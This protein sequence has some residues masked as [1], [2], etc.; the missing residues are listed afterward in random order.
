MTSRKEWLTELDTSKKS[1]V[2]FAD[3]R[4]VTA[5]GIG[6]V[7]IRRRDGKLALIKNVLYVPGMKCNLLSLG[8]LIERGFSVEMKNQ[9]LKMY[10]SDHQLIMR[11]PLSNNR[12]FQVDIET[13]E[14]QCMAAMTS[15]ETWLW[16]SRYGHLNFK[17]LQ[18]LSAR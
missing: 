11:A 1:K 16:H 15:D 3:F 5:E 9:S 17:A 7:A 13:T 14:V 10:D 6:N 4:S 2:R 12:T 18:Q 8:Q